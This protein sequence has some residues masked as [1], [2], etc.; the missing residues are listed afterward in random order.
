MHAPRPARLILLNVINSNH[1][2]YPVKRTNYLTKTLK[3]MYLETVF[4]EFP[5]RA[6]LPCLI[7]TKYALMEMEHIFLNSL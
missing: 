6:E 1:S 4:I 7:E 2:L 5:E 3:K